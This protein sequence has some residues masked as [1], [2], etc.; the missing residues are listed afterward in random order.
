MPGHEKLLRRIRSCAL[1]HDLRTHST[2]VP[3]LD[4]KMCRFLELALL[5]DQYPARAPMGEVL[6]RPLA[7]FLLRLD[8]GAQV[9][10]D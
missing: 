9:M 7:A 5:Q 6:H 1:W 3:N 10:H 8:L 4:L 2:R